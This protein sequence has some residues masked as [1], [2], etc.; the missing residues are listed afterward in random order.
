MKYFE[1]LK[2]TKYLIISMCLSIPTLETELG[3]SF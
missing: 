1:K 2:G 3:H